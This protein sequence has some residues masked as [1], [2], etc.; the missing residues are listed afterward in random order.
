[1]SNPTANKKVIAIGG[2]AGLHGLLQGL[3]AYDLDLT[4]IITVADDGGSSGRIRKDFNIPP[5]GDI[6]RCLVALSKADPLIADL[7]EYRFK[8]GS[9]KGHSFGNL[10]IAVLAELSGDFRQALERA[11]TLLSVDGA[12]IPATDVKVVLVA[13]HPDGSKSTG[14]QAISRSSKPIQ[15]LSLVPRPPKVSAEICEAIAAADLICLG[16]G[17]L[18][19]SIM[20]NLL[21]PGLVAAINRADAKVLFVAN[22]LTQPGE[23]DDFD[24]ESHLRAFDRLEQPLQLDE[25]MIHDDDID[26]ATKDTG[27]GDLAKVVLPR[28]SATRK[29]PQLI[30]RP[31]VASGRKVRHDPAKLARAIRARLVDEETGREATL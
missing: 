30:R 10:F 29:G 31:L 14:E 20:P 12:V 7:F 19:T 3:M 9:L 8:K 26:L 4:A 16:P 27:Y 18:Y 24:L 28:M 2:G 15:S 22:L 6:R 21:V 5:P 23:T 17:S 13:D 11:R 1:M 25:V